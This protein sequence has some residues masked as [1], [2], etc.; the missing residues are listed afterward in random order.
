[1]KKRKKMKIKEVL[2]YWLPYIMGGITILSIFIGYVLSVGWENIYFFQGNTAKSALSG[3]I[4][5]DLMAT[6]KA[7][8]SKAVRQLPVIIALSQII[9]KLKQ[10]IWYVWTQQKATAGFTF[11]MLIQWIIGLMRKGKLRILLIFEIIVVA[12]WKHNGMGYWS[13]TAM[14]AYYF[15]W[16]PFL[17]FYF[18]LF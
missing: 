8:E 9:N 11:I 1:M 3:R 7:T 5:G 15:F 13:S 16:A 18:F 2:F 14:Y 6:G 12:F 4:I 10:V 17:Y